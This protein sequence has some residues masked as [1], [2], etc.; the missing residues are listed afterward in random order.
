MDHNLLHET[1]A[2]KCQMLNIHTGGSLLGKHFIPFGRSGGMGD[3]IMTQIIHQQNTILK[4]TK[5]RILQNLKYINEI[6]E[7][8]LSEDIAFATDGAFT[9][10][11]AFT[12]YKDNRG[13]PLFTSFKST[14][15]ALPTVFY[16]MK[17]TRLR[18]TRHY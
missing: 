14:Q 2:Q 5:Q 15:R 17:K 12:C 3:A 11:E 18:W 8:P 6:I 9:I 10:R 16:S 1:I 13:G 7:M 4:Q